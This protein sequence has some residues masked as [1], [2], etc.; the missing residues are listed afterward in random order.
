M[1]NPPASTLRVRA[2][3]SS[4]RSVRRAARSRRHRHR[5]HLRRRLLNRH[6]RH[7]LRRQTR[8]RFRRLPLR[9]VRAAYAI[10]A[11]IPRP[12]RTATRRAARGSARDHCARAARAR[13]RPS[14]RAGGKLR[15]ASARSVPRASPPRAFSARFPHVHVRT[16]QHAFPPAREISLKVAE[17]PTILVNDARASCFIA[18]F[19]VWNG[20]RSAR[21]ARR[22]SRGWGRSHAS[23]RVLLLKRLSRLFFLLT[24]FWASATLLAVLPKSKCACARLQFQLFDAMKVVGLRAARG[25]RRSSIRT[26]ITSGS[27]KRGNT[28]PQKRK[29]SSLLNPERELPRVIIRVDSPKL[30]RYSVPNLF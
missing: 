5:L 16:P 6:P 28:S 1:P 29:L 13:T 21:H 30:G 22:A 7:L 17:V 23:R 24:A 15:P 27:K 3:N 14:H 26:R 18:L 12:R 10:S 19:G 11:S 2:E 25:T 9:S 4:A 20:S 8:P